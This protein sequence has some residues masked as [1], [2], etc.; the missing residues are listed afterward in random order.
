M[1][2]GYINWLWAYICI[3]FIYYTMRVVFG[4]TFGCNNLRK[5]FR[6][7]YILLSGLLPLS[8]YKPKLLMAT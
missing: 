3:A 5:R 2:Y 7:G 6:S 1:A 8:I 4:T